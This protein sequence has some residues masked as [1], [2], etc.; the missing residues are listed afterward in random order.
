ME[1]TGFDDRERRL[2]SETLGVLIERTSE[3]MAY[4]LDGEDYAAG[5]PATIRE[6]EAS[7]E[8]QR[9]SGL[10]TLPLQTWQTMLAPDPDVPHAALRAALEVAMQ[11]LG[12]ALDLVADPAPLPEGVAGQL[13]AVFDEL[14][15]LHHT[16]TEGDEEEE[17]DA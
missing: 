14:G 5:D 8:C 12:T 6:R 4:T 2:L 15:W 13:E 7:D 9:L 1:Q 16:L 17:D 10:L 3:Q 11:A